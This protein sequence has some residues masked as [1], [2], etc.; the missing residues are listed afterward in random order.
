MQCTTQGQNSNQILEL[1]NTNLASVLQ[2]PE[3]LRKMF[4]KQGSGKLAVDSLKIL[5]G[6]VASDDID[7]LINDVENHATDSKNILYYITYI[8]INYL[9]IVIHLLKTLIIWLNAKC[10][11][12]TFRVISALN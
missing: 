2:N 1:G 10:V 4:S 6:Q 12:Q 5:A 3:L 9:D 11:T 7:R 8:C